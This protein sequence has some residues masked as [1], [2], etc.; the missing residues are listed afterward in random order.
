[1]RASLTTAGERVGIDCDVAW[2]AELLEEASAGHLESFDPARAETVTVRVEVE[3]EPFAIDDWPVLTR[4]AWYREGGAV[5]VADACTSGFDLRL[6]ME[7]DRGQPHPVFTFR[8]RP[9]RTSR[10]ANLALRSRFILLARAALLQ[11][12]ALWAAGL[13]GRAPLHVSA[14]TVASADPATVVLAGPGGVGKSTLLAAEMAAGGTATSD[15]LCVSDGSEVWGVVEPL[16][17]E[18]DP[19]HGG[20]AGRRMPFGRRET[21]FDGRVPSLVPNHVLVLRRGQGERPGVAPAASETAARSLVAGTYVAGE[22]RRYWGLAATLAA[23]TGAGPVHPPV[24]DVAAAL[25]GATTCLDV[26]LARRPGARLG[27]LLHPTEA[28]SCT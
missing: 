22:L 19:H 26:T 1:M 25:A 24:I 14:C 4:G 7:S 17:L 20:E 16:R 15:N 3:H 21:T 5:V 8:W 11:Y 9:P 18:L 6:E 2:V 28:L 10:V 12:P 23:G 27:D 13:R